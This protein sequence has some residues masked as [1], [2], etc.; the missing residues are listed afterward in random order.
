[1]TMS[2]EIASLVSRIGAVA[3]C[4]MALTIVTSSAS[5]GQLAH[6][7]QTSVSEVERELRYVVSGHFDA[8]PTDFNVLRTHCSRRGDSP[9]RFHC[10][11]LASL[12]DSEYI[13]R[14]RVRS[15]DPFEGLGLAY[16]FRIR[17]LG[18]DGKGPPSEKHD[19]WHGI[20]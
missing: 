18:Y 1:M 9:N 4:L 14:G 5:A 12:G 16:G 7:Q 13:G 20:V 11:F 2:P 17:I 3:A 6:P 10:R 19:R 15:I 8:A